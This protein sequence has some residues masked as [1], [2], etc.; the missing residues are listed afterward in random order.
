MLKNYFKIAWRSILKNKGTALIN[1]AG[2]SVG[3]AAAIFI[4]FWVQN[5][6][7]FDNYHPE[8]DRVYRLT[9]SIKKVDM[10]WEGTPLLLADEA[11]KQVPEIEKVARLYANKWPVF[12]INDNI[13]YEKKTAYVD[14]DWFTIFHYD[15]I[16]GDAAV[17][18]QNPY[19]IILTAT[20]AKKYFGNKEA[21]GETIRIDS[22]LYQVKAIVAD[23]PVNSS[24]QYQAFLPMAA[25]LTDRQQKENDENWDNFNYI[26]FI[27]V[28]ANSSTLATAKKTNGS[29]TR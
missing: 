15:F 25:L 26:T 17:F 18:A 24:F 3:M 19:S 7:R 28:K 1:I 2:L 10:V 20:A 21:I 8:A 29:Y 13:I 11:K 14:A 12:T 16:E 6:M 5:E 23:A 22:M 9:T 4:L 27:K